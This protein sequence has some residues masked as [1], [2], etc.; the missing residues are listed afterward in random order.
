[1]HLKRAPRNANGRI[2]ALALVV[3]IDLRPELCHIEVFG[4][5]LDSKGVQSG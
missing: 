3:G 4:D 1:M 5:M 2:F